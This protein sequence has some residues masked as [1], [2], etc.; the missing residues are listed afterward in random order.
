MTWV[1]VAR[2][3]TSSPIDVTVLCFYG[4]L[5]SPHNK[6]GVTG[7][8]ENLSLAGRG[9]DAPSPSGLPLQFRRLAA[10][11][12]ICGGLEN[13]RG[14]EAPLSLGSGSR[15]SAPG[16]RLPALG[17]RLPV[18]GSRLPAPSPRL[19]AWSRFS[20]DAQPRRGGVRTREAVSSDP[21]AVRSP[22]EP[23]SRRDGAAAPGWSPAPR[24]IRLREGGGEAAPGGGGGPRDCGSP[25]RGGWGAVRPRGR[26][27]RGRGTGAGGA[28]SDSGEGGREGGGWA[29]GREPAS[30]PHRASPPGRRF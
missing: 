28:A 8:T 30:T 27:E 1:L 14:R 16:S 4:R 24:R 20:K 22:A 3:P 13:W 2:M 25:P 18:P 6:S 29:E 17:S 23:G 21:P 5:Q 11:G 9:G 12:G 7:S 19:P 10:G 26:A 15:L